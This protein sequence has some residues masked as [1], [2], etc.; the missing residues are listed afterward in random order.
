MFL[1]R[2]NRIYRSEILSLAEM[3]DTFTCP[4][5]GITT[6]RL[7][8]PLKGNRATCRGQSGRKGEVRRF[9]QCYL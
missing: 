3:A 7:L 6:S 9:N 8:S 1:S 5:V 4:D 2:G